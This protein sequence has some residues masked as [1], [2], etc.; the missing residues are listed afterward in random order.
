MDTVT[1]A[2]FPEGI[3][4]FFKELAENNNKQWFD[5]HR[6]EY[7]QLVKE[8]AQ[9]FADAMSDRLV[10]IAAGPPPRAWV[11]RINRDI[12]FSKDKSPYKTHVG[13]AFG[14]PAGKKDE[15]PGFYFHLE[16]PTVFLGGGMH[17]FPKPALELYRTAVGDEAEGARL[18]ALLAAVEQAGPYEIWGESYKRVPQGFPADHPNADLLKYSGLFGG[19]TLTE[20]PELYS[21]ALLDLCA[22]HYEAVAPIQRWLVET[23][24]R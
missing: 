16:P 13:V 5:A 12:R 7:V 6:E 17:T 22:A 19:L 1:F 15:S 9:A 3:A 4:G 23:L 20:P 24:T 14:D 11:F 8:P 10:E 21:P 18:R 2:G